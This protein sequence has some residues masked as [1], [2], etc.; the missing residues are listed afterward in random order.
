MTQK[1]F[2]AVADFLL[3]VLF[4]PVRMFGAG[5]TVQEFTERFPG[6]CPICSF[7]RYGLQHD[8]ATGPVPPHGGC[9]EHG[10]EAPKP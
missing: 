8:C 2:N 1:V 6:R 9:H 5:K 7:H 4:L 3:L 10:A